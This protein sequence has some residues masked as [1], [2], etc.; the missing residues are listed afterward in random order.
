[1]L[2]LPPSRVRELAREALA[3]LSPRSAERVDPDWRGQLAD[4]LLGQQSGPEATATQAHLKR[5][6]AARTWA[7]SVLDALDSLYANGNR[8]SIPDMEDGARA[9]GGAG[10]AVE[11]KPRRRE[12]ERARKERAAAAAAAKSDG[13]REKKAEAEAEAAEAPERE[14]PPAAAA[15]AKPSARGPLSPAAR[16]ALRRRRLIGG[17]IGLV[18]LLALTAGILAL[19]GVFSGDDN[20]GGKTST[21]SAGSTT[22]TPA[23]AQ[24]GGQPQVLGQIPLQPQGGVR[25]QGNAYILRQGNQQ[26]LAV[27]AKLP[28]LPSTQRKAAYNVWLFNNPKDAQSIGAQFTTKAGDYQGVGPL[29]ANYKRFRFIDVSRQ[30]FSNKS[31]HSGQSVL[32]GAFASLRPVPQGQQPPGTQGGGGG[33]P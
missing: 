17:A 15:A 31:G 6:E 19:A 13:D 23:A 8:P 22:P 12:R 21:Q 30:P 10:A 25:A 3:E 32:R 33:T 24:Q 7:L 2:D 5:S 29:P 4:Y 1:M 27:T 11:E 16:A 14:S 28:P 18:A 20:G 26:I 9:R